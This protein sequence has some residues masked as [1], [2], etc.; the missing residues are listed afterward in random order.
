MHIGGL[1]AELPAGRSSECESW[2]AVT[3]EDSLPLTTR[4]PPVRLQPWAPDSKSPPG[5]SE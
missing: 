4:A 2:A 1:V 5:R 3:K